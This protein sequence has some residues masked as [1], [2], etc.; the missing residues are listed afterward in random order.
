MHG[1]AGI[2]FQL[3]SRHLGIISGGSNKSILGGGG[4]GG[5]GD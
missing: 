1:P 2:Q 5:G 4:G 3:S